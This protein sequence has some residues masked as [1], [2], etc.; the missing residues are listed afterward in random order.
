VITCVAPAPAVDRLLELPGPVTP[1]EIHRPAR[2]LAVAGGK[3]LNVARAAA[4]LGA[5]V[6]AV[7]P[8]GG[9][10]GR[11]IE[12]R[13]AAAGID[14]R[15][16]TTSAEPRV[17]ISIAS[18]GQELTEFYE[19]AP[20]LEPGQWQAFE[21]AVREAAQGAAWVTLSGSLPPGS[22]DDGAERLVAAGHAAGARVALDASGEAL[23]SGLRAAPDLVKVNTRE[24]RELLGADATASALRRA[25]G[26]ACITNGAAGIELAAGDVRLL[27]VPPVRGDY[28]VG[29]GDVTLAALVAARSHGASWRAALALATAASAASAEIP[30]AGV[31]DAARAWRLAD[32]VTVRERPS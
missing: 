26:A 14:V 17:C 22:P 15:R 10:T 4:A 1:G 11:W 24:A 6:R 30:G 2:V 9:A 5:P 27:A 13:L 16:V 32:A 7:A 20:R 3:G 21:R 19:P 28:P 29:C 18:S 31:L 12:E 23:R 8:L 25:G